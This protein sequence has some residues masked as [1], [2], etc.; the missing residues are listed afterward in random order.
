[1][2]SGKGK[3]K[4]ARATA[5]ASPRIITHPKK[6]KELVSRE[7]IKDVTVN[8][9][10]SLKHHPLRDLSDVR[11]YQTKVVE[12]LFQDA[13]SIGVIQLPQDIKPHDF[14]F[15]LK[16]SD[17]NSGWFSLEH[18]ILHSPDY[19]K[20][21]R[22]TDDVSLTLASTMNGFAT[23]LFVNYLS[24]IVSAVVNDLGSAKRIT[25]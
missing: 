1:M 15:V 13:L 7:E 6:W 3:T 2:G 24:Q 4:R 9:Y 23:E 17:S 21:V 11:D 12:E 20:Q 14:I 22:C 19:M 8:D 10:Y 18:V 5:T 16:P 25:P